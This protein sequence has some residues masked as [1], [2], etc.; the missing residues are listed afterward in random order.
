M[1]QN[2]SLFALFALAWSILTGNTELYALTHKPFLSGIFL[3]TTEPPHLPASSPFFL[4]QDQPPPQDKETLPQGQ[5]SWPTFPNAPSGP[6]GKNIKI[7]PDRGLS[8]QEKEE[9]LSGAL[10]NAASAFEQKWSKGLNR[11]PYPYFENLTSINSHDSDHNRPAWFTTKASLWWENSRRK[12]FF[13]DHR[14]IEGISL[15]GFRWTHLDGKTKHQASSDWLQTELGLAFP[16]PGGYANLAFGGSWL[17]DHD[18]FHNKVSAD[19]ATSFVLYP[20]YPL[21][22]QAHFRSSFFETGQYILDLEVSGKLQIF[23][24]LFFELGWRDLSTPGHRDLFRADG[25]F[26]GIS[27]DF[28]NLKFA[29]T[30]PAGGPADGILGFFN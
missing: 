30:P 21:G 16:L 22:L 28:S 17:D 20:F 19:A 3:E 1:L 25:I 29:F 23:R 10:N 26:F 2:L 9:A 15:H 12:G 11:A 24:S 14:G 7:I 6:S 13:V 4:I 8:E 18:H 5:L 27:F